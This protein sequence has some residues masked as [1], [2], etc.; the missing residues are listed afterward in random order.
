[1]SHSNQTSSLTNPLNTEQILLLLLDSPLNINRL[2]IHSCRWLSGQSWQL[3]S[4]V[5]DSVNIK[6]SNHLPLIILWTHHSYYSFR[7]NNK[8]VWFP[9][10]AA[11]AGLKVSNVQSGADLIMSFFYLYKTTVPQPGMD[12]EDSLTGEAVERTLKHN[13]ACRPQET[14]LEEKVM[15][16]CS[17]TCSFCFVHLHLICIQQ[18]I[19]YKLIPLSCSVFSLLT[20]LSDFRFSEAATAGVVRAV[21]PFVITWPSSS[22]WE[23]RALPALWKWCVHTGK[24]GVSRLR[25]FKK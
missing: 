4:H 24:K 16:K 25:W 12:L 7:C 2:K 1:M 20:S 21:L 23:R 9:A 5:S 10:A 14:I 6:V 19:H 8:S 13:T 11:A 17:Q 15:G 22:G 3:C 18:S